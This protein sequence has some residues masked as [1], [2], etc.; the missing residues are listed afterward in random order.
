M[1]ATLLLQNIG[2]GLALIVGLNG[3]L[4]PVHMGKAVGLEYSNL[5]GLVEL[6]V[7]FGSFLVALPVY[8]LW[9]Q[10]SELFIF[11]GVAA[12]AAFLIKTSFTI[13]DRCPWRLIRVGILVDAVLALC[14]LSP[15]YLPS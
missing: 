6:R 5:V 12:F 10:R 14:L 13:I 4:R 7:L 3:L 11:F 15:W 8:A 1:S 2:A 9:Q